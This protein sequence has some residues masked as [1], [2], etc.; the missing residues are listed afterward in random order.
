MN[1][2][3]KVQKYFFAK[4]GEKEEVKAVEG[5]RVQRQAGAK[6]IYDPHFSRPDRD[7]VVKGKR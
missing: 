3:R 7:R 2:E 4:S 6:N 1:L 5:N